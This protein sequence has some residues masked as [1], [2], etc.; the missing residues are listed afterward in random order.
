[1]SQ[2]A[3]FEDVSNNPAIYDQYGSPDQPLT[4]I[5]L[6]Q[7]EATAPFEAA[8]PGAE[9]LQ[10]PFGIGIAVV[11]NLLANGKHEKGNTN[12]ET[13]WTLKDDQSG[14]KLDTKYND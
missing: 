9:N 1:M 12:P 13:V 14:Y 3:L 4:L 10:V 5:T 6:Q 2:I 11:G 7:I 8:P